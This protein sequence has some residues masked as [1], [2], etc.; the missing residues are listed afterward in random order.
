MGVTTVT[1][2]AILAF[3]ALIA[4][5]QN[6]NCECD[7]LTAP[8]WDDCETIA[9]TLDADP[10]TYKAGSDQLPCVFVDPP[11]DVDPDS[12][13]CVI[14]YC[15]KDGVAAGEDILYQDI[16]L[17]YTTVTST[18][19]A[20][21]GSPGGKC[22]TTGPA[23]SD[24]KVT[25]E[26]KANPNYSAGARRRATEPVDRVISETIVWAQPPESQ[27]EHA[28]DFP[29]DLSKRQTPPDS[30]DSFDLYV[31]SRNV[32]NPNGGRI[33]VFGPSPSGSTY[34]V[35]SSR[36]ETSSVSS[37]ASLSVGFFEIFEASVS[38]DVGYEETISESEGYSVPIDCPSGQRGIIYWTPLYTRYQG[39]YEPSGTQV[40]WYIANG[41]TQTSYVL[42]CIG[43]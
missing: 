35:S 12:L 42:Q 17:Q 32:E 19:K 28:R 4:N 2:A 34:T 40:E 37:S 8:V 43:Q 22:G 16:L 41:G 18:C 15:K 9:S 23:Q 20:Q 11:A 5:A 31:T 30:D 6:F 24:R 39:L 38:I 27:R 13:N 21:N 25:V 33:K 7:G 36:S 14:T 29:R 1:A 3:N 26:A 10:L